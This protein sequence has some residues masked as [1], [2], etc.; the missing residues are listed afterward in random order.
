MTNALDHHRILLLR[1][2]Q[3]AQ[4]T[5]EALRRLGAEPVIVPLMQI[6]DPP[7]WT[8]VDEVLRRI[9]GF[10][11]VVFTSGEA[12]ARVFHRLQHLGV[13]WPESIRIAVVGAQTRHLVESHGCM[14]DLM[15]DKHY[16]QEGLM[17]AFMMRNLQEK[18]I[19]LPGG[20]K[21][22][23]DLKNFLRD[24][25]AWVEPLVI[26]R[27]VMHLNSEQLREALDQGIDAIVFT[28]SS[29]VEA[30]LHNIDGDLRDC[31]RNVPLF[32]IGP[33]TSSTLQH[34]GLTVTAQAPHATLD[35]VILVLTEYFLGDFT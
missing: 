21:N 10:D 27:N 17:D 14:V 28:A 26:Y 35:S 34:E 20:Q 3:K 22:R 13:A 7:S 32:S 23:S 6:E 25:G 29:T 8:L 11:W 30:F 5:A 19:F 4:T 1:D 31:V 24:R 2:G 33:Q 12:V 16:S 15:P 9:A 18:H